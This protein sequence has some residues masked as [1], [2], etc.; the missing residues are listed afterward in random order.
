MDVSDV[1]PR[2]RAQPSRHLES[3][4]TCCVGAE[5]RSCIV[6]LGPRLSCPVDGAIYGIP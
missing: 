1:M 6:V 3:F 2:Q 5:G 4:T